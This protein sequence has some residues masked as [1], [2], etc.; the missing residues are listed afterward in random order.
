[1]ESFALLD[2]LQITDRSFPTGGFVHSHGLE[3]L[4][5]HE[6]VSL[7]SVLRMRLQEQLG[8][9]ELVFLVQAYEHDAENL[10]GRFHAM[11]LPLESREASMQMG[12]QFLRNACDLFG[13]PALEAAAER[14]PCC[15]YP[16]VYGVVAQ[17]LGMAPRTAALTYAFQSVRGQ[18]SAAQ[19]LTRLGQTEAQR[20][21]HR[22]KPLIGE[23]VATALWYPLEDAAPF[24]P[25][26]DIASMAHERAEV[27]LFVS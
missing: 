14:L 15:H 4:V 3:W 13:L 11:L 18:I 20:I 7:E 1:M 12:R 10:D 27:R 21:L 24:V 2:L 19:R 25:L 9:F 6:P 8:H 5:K 16:V 26:L 17:A 22:M 23:A